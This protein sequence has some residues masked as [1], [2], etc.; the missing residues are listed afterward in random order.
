MEK[1]NKKTKCLLLIYQNTKKKE[2]NFYLP[3][4]KSQ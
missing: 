4:D 2:K 3:F 1:E